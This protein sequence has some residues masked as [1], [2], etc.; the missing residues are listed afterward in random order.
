MKISIYP[1]L[2]ALALFAGCSGSLS[3]SIYSDLNG[4]NVRDEDEPGLANKD[5][6]ITKDG[7]MISSGHTDELGNYEIKYKG[8][9]GNFCTSVK[10]SKIAFNKSVTAKGP[11]A[12]DIAN[13]A[14]ASKAAVSSN[15]SDNALTE[16]EPCGYTSDCASGLECADKICSKPVAGTA[17]LN[18]ACDTS[19]DCVSGLEC[20]AAGR[21]V[22]ESKVTQPPLVT[23]PAPFQTCAKTDGTMKDLN[24]DVPISYDISATISQQIP[25]FETADIEAGKPFTL[26]IYYPG[27]C[28][29]LDIVLP[30][31]VK[32]EGT[33][34]DKSI[35]FSLSNLQF[36]RNRD[37]SFDI[38]TPEY[39]LSLDVAELVSVKLV[40][41]PASSKSKTI[42]FAPKVV[43]PDG[44]IWPLNTI[45]FNVTG[46]STGTPAIA[47]NLKIVT[48]VTGELK[49]GAKST[50]RVTVVNKDSKDH[51]GLELIIVIPGGITLNSSDEEIKAQSKSCKKEY[52]RVICGIET[53]AASVGFFPLDI[54]YTLPNKTD[55]DYSGTI[56]IELNDAGGNKVDSYDI[57]IEL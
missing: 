15:T 41:P 26:D 43:C 6:T 30:K 1:L 45:E 7:A 53:I 14:T 23:T 52:K 28:Q 37:P 40:A 35:L 4:N 36:D 16:G 22:K 54:T 50:L 10:K 31:G 33:D 19:D 47:D 20:S 34:S 29:L 57:D 18:Q 38:A 55:E 2:V 17:T 56:S 9:S 42:A 25:D 8:E 24:L 51:S 39:D 46:T 11:V 12:K 3:G 27:S 44:K 48:E 21:C 49:A 13:N 32:L 5:Y